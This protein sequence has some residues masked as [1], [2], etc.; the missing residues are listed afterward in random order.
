VNGVEKGGTGGDWR[1]VVIGNERVLKASSCPPSIHH[2]MPEPISSTTSLDSLASATQGR[3]KVSRSIMSF[4]DL[5]LS[6]Q[7]KLDEF[8]REHD[9]CVIVYICVEEHLHLVLALAGMWIFFIVGLIL[10]VE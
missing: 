6:D 9:G 1:H 2:S 5:V 8:I 4:V 3:A 10:S 7:L